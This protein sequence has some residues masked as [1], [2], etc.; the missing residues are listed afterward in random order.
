M[1]FPLAE[2]DFDAGLMKLERFDGAVFTEPLR[3]YDREPN[4]RSLRI[5]Y[6][7]HTLTLQLP[8]GSSARIQIHLEGRAAEQFLRER[9]VVYLDQN[10]WST[11]A[12][13]RFGGR[14]VTPAQARAAE[15]IWGLVDAGEIVLP[16]SA[17]H[18]L[19]TGALYGSRRQEVACAVLGRSAAG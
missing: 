11:I 1:L 8:D 16:L 4:I 3:E 6:S 19:E 13:W 17:G 10:Q 12:A 14:V 15:E 18:M 5:D 7:A 2:L 9:A